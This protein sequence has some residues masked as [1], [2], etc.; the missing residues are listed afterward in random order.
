ME[1]NYESRYNQGGYMWQPSGHKK[2][3]IED[4]AYEYKR[5]HFV[6]DVVMYIL[7]KYIKE[8][9]EKGEQPKIEYVR[10]DLKEDRLGKVDLFIKFMGD[11]EEIKFQLTTRKNLQ[12]LARKKEN[13]PKYVAFVVLESEKINE[14]WKGYL[15]AKVDKPDLVVDEFLSS[16]DERILRRIRDEY[17]YELFRALPSEK[18]E[19]IAYLL[20]TEE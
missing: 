15:N 10:R 9:L 13:L 7:N 17:L 20:Q 4:K 18:K 11:D 3:D 8:S 19:R 1:R 16:I 5:G 6:E 14:L 2:I 12:E